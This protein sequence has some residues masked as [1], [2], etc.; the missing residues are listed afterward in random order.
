MT[1]LSEY[2]EQCIVADYM[3]KRW[4]KV[5]FTATLGGVRV[6]IGAA[7]KLKKQGYLKGVPDLLIC[8]PTKEAW[9]Y[10]DTGR[11]IYPYSYIGLAIEMKV[12]KGGVVSDDQKRVMAQFEREGWKVLVAHGA[13]EAIKAI[14][15]YL[16]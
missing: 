12:G 8:K 11:T 1:P 3:R 10:T 16:K 2:Q 14:E 4:P 7:V 6:S 5:L 9:I 15:E 13:D